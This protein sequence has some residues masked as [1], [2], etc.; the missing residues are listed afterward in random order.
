VAARLVEVRLVRWSGLD[1]LSLSS[2][3]FD[4]LRKFQTGAALACMIYL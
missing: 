3:R 1:L 4:P 2:S